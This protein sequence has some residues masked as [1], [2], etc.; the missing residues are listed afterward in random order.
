[1]ESIISRSNQI[2]VFDFPPQSNRNYRLQ[3]TGYSDKIYS[4]K[5]SYYYSRIKN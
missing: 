5:T 3:I 2:F 1:M 4:N